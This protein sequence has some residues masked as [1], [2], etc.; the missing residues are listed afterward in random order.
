VYIPL[1]LVS[2]SDSDEMS[3]SVD[4]VGTPGAAT[5]V[6]VSVVLADMP[7]HDEIQ[8]QYKLYSDFSFSVD[9]CTSLFAMATFPLD[10]LGDLVNIKL[11]DDTRSM[12]Y[13]S[14]VW[15]FNTFGRVE[16]DELNTACFF[17]NAY[18]QP[19][20]VNS[21][22][23]GAGTMFIARRVIQADTL[24][25]EEATRRLARR[26]RRKASGVDPQSIRAS[27]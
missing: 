8:Y 3:I 17:D 6:G 2:L 24:R 27:V 26:A 5:S 12:T 11:G 18:G 10:T 21:S 13:R 9:A 1:G 4:C 14:G 25:R 7:E 15:F 19:V 22:N 16:A 23:P 20:V